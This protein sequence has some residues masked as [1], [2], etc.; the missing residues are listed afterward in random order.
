MHLVKQRLKDPPKVLNRK[1]LNPEQTRGMNGLLARGGMQRRNAGRCK[2][3][4]KSRTR[5][6]ICGDGAILIK[7]P[8]R[9]QTRD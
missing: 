7:E 6:D 1:A 5:L 2:M 3:Q 4:K 8:G 9:I